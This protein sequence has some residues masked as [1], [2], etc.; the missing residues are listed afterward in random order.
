MSKT[1]QEQIEELILEI[2][3]R[4]SDFPN[5]MK[6]YRT[7]INK[8]LIKA[9]LDMADN[10]IDQERKLYKVFGDDNKICTGIKIMADEVREYYEGGKYTKYQANLKG[11]ED[12]SVQIANDISP[13]ARRNLKKYADSAKSNS[14][15][16]K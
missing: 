3:E 2:N 15:K 9:R 10:L 13:E 16:D 14:Q 12:L 1:S 4:L 5:L 7:K 8:L 6:I 11:D